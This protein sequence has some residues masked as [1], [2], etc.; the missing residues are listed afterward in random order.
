MLQIYRRIDQTITLCNI[1]IYLPVINSYTLDVIKSDDTNCG[2][3]GQ[4]RAR[5]FVMV[6]ENVI[7]HDIII[8]I[9]EH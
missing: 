6:Y 9:F 5:L 4:I 1:L 2:I 8:Y 7:T 3:F